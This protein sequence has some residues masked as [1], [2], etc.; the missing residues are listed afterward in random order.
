LG[1]GV[2]NAAMRKYLAILFCAMLCAGCAGDKPTGPKKT[3]KPGPN[4]PVVTPDFRSVGKVTR[5]SAEG[6]FVVVNFPPGQM[7]EPDALLNVYRNGLKV[8]EVKV[9]G[10]WQ[11]D[12]NSV[13]DIITGD[14]QAG[15][16][17]RQN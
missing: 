4:K 11:R 1:A 10:K 12:N 9:D 15:D 2:F 8:A 16:E 13:A 17:A 5:V 3:A 14:V 7:P 6:R